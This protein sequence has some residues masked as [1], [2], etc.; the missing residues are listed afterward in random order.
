VFEKYYAKKLPDKKASDFVF[1]IPGLPIFIG[2]LQLVLLVIDFR[3]EGNEP[4]VSHKLIKD[5]FDTQRKLSLLITEK[6]NN[7]AVILT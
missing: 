2:L 5:R 7:V 4:L 6:V 3:L 1:K